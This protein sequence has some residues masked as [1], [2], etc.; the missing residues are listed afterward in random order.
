MNSIWPGQIIQFRPGQAIQHF[1][2]QSL[3]ILIQWNVRSFSNLVQS[4]NIMFRDVGW[5]L[6]E[7]KNKPTFHPTFPLFSNVQWNVISFDLL[8]QHC[9][10]GVCTIVG[11]SRKN[12]IACY[13]FLWKTSCRPVRDS[14]LLQYSLHIAKYGNFNCTNYTFCD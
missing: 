1:I 5:N 14:R 11:F 2:K 13:W 8:T 9:P 6:L 3:N 4:P 7:I 10:I 12:L